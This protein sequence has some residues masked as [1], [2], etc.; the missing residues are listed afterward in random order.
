MRVVACEETGR[1]IDK[2]LI[3]IAPFARK[4]I[5]EPIG[6]VPE[7]VGE[8]LQ[9]LVYGVGVEPRPNGDAETGV[10]P[11]LGMEARK[12]AQDLLALLRRGR[13]WPCC[14]DDVCIGQIFEQKVP[15][16]CVQVPM[17]FKATRDEAFRHHRGNL[18]VESDLLATTSP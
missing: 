2:L 14:G 12:G 1:R 8:P 17:G 15:R 13:Q 6:K 7:S 9:V 4:P 18:G 10:I 5:T 11:P 16:V 3:Q